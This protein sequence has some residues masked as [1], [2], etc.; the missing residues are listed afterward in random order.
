M[1][2]T[3]NGVKNSSDI[4]YI[5]AGD[6]EPAV[7]ANPEASSWYDYS[8]YGSNYGNF[9]FNLPTTDV[10]GNYIDQYYL[11]YSIYT[12]NDQIYTFRASD[13]PNELTEDAT[14]ITSSVFYNSWNLS[15]YGVSLYYDEPPL[16]YHRVGI[17]V[18]YT[19]DGV[20][21]ASDIIYLEVFPPSSVDEQIT[22]KQV[23]NVRYF[24][25]AGQEMA[26]PAGLT[27][28]VTTFTDG[29]T[30]ATKVIK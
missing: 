9:Y 27:I 8:E 22:G 15:T 11:S 6:L 14:E 1:Y 7:P 17:Q 28:Q 10:D 23:A 16:F 26:Q 2:Y 18:F 21:N 30:T 19:I 12:D 3:V 4:V 29:T 24:N 5:N 13:F 20:K 25:V